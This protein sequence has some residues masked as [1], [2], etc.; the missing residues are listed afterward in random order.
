MSNPTRIEVTE[1][2]LSD[3]YSKEGAQNLSSILYNNK[4]GLK[5]LVFSGCHFG[6]DSVV[7]IMEAITTNKNILKN[8]ES[9]R[10]DD[11]CIGDQGANAIASWLRKSQVAVELG[12]VD[13]GITSKGALEI[14][15]A[16]DLNETLDTF[17]SMELS[18]E[19]NLTDD[20]LDELLDVLDSVG[21]TLKI[22]KGKKRKQKK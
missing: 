18:E 20:A 10:F 21:G 13:A 9:L 4:V 16:L 17:E 5:R 2:F 8:L 19:D 3:K 6:P 15:D 7:T 11:N 12:L 14:A 22:A 1:V